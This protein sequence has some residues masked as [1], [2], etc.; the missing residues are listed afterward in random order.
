MINKIKNIWQ[1]KRSKYREIWKN[2][3]T[4]TIIIAVVI[5]AAIIL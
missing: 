4:C 1:S 2:H 5:I 3:K